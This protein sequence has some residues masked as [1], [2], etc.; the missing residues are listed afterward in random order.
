MA[1]IS[2]IKSYEKRL[3][4]AQSELAKGNKYYKGDTKLEIARASGLLQ[5]AKNYGRDYKVNKE[6]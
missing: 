1:N 2:N 6:K 3:L 4:K 5:V